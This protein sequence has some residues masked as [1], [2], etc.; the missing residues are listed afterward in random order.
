MKT[1]KARQ[2]A[3]TLMHHIDQYLLARA[4]DAQDHMREK[5]VGAIET[6]LSA[7]ALGSDKPISTHMLFLHR[8][9]S[10]RTINCLINDGFDAPEQLL[11]ASTTRFDKIHGIG[12]NSIDEIMR[13]I[14]RF[15]YKIGSA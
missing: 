7:P 9:F 11:T 5:L 2:R 6:L 8:G 3:E 15:T 4:T 14:D 13:Y 1:T 12:Q 10:T